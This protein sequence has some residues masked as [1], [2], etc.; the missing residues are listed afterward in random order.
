MFDHP[1]LL[2]IAGILATGIVILALPEMDD[3]L[4]VVSAVAGLVTSLAVIAGSL[5][6]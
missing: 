1:L 4:A 3:R 5:M 2:L 6:V